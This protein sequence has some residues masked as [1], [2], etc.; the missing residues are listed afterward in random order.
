MLVIMVMKKGKA[1]FSNI[2]SKSATMTGNDKDYIEEIE[3][4]FSKK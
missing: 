4:K 3:L 2:T 1:T